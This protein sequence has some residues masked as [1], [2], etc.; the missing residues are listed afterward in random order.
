MD[1]EGPSRHLE[2]Q[3]EFNGDTDWSETHLFE[4]CSFDA[5]VG[6]WVSLTRWPA[7][8]R[9]WFWGA[10]VREGRPTVL[11][12]DQDIPIPRSGTLELRAPGL[13]ADHICETPFRHWTAAMEAFGVA[14]EDPLEAFARGFGE[15]V[16]IG[17]DLEWEHDPA[18]LVRSD[19]EQ[20]FERYDLGAVVTGEVLVGEEVLVID[21][22]GSRSHWWGTS[23]WGEAPGEGWAAASDTPVVRGEIVTGPVTSDRLASPLGARL[24]G[25]EWVVDELVGWSAVPIPARTPSLAGP[26]RLMARAMVRYRALSGERAVGWL[27]AYGQ[28]G[29]AAV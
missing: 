3:Q 4:L 10:L 14:L 7:H 8:R 16:P 27:T 24:L 18:Q 9:F 12:V 25:T 21:G 17:H 26:A 11:V 19:P 2:Q 29:T 23:G 6:V 28:P 15:R 5:T 13:W 20:G 22:V 1:P